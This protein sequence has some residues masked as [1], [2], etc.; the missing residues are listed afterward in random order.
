VAI[1]NNGPAA[2]S[3]AAWKL[4][5]IADG[6]PAFTFPGGSIQPGQ[7][8]RV[9]TNEVHP[10]WGGYSFAYGNAIWNNCQPDTAGLF[11]PGGALVSQATYA[12]STAGC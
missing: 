7:E 4:R 11:N 2:V 6:S 10:Q 9:Y 12:K 8:V 5:D 3:L 1:K